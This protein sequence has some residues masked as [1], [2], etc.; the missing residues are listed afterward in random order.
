MIVFDDTRGCTGHRR[1]SKSLYVC[2]SRSV[3]EGE[4][5]PALC[6][7]PTCHIAGSR[8]TVRRLGDPSTRHQASSR[9]TSLTRTRRVYP[10]CTSNLG[11]VEARLFESV[12]QFSNAVGGRGFDRRETVEQCASPNAPPQ[13]YRRPLMVLTA[14]LS[15]PR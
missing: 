4:D 13:A 10:A 15:A 1:G 6:A 14:L 3:E 12:D 2:S 7:R 5:Q 8:W 9:V 11:H